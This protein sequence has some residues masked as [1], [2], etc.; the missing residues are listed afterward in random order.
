MTILDGKQCSA[1]LRDEL[2]QQIQANVLLGHRAPCLGIIQVGDISASTTYVDNKRK[3]CEYVGITACMLHLPATITQEY[4]I[5]RL[6]AWNSDPDIDGYIVQL[7]LPNH[8]NEQDV[9]CTIAAEKDVDGFSPTNMGKL[10]MGWEGLPPAMPMGIHSL[11]KEYDIPLKGKEVAIIGGNHLLVRPLANLLSDKGVDC[12]VTICHPF[13]QDVR[14][15]C[16]NADIVISAMDQPGTVTV[17]MVREGAIVVDAGNHYL[18]APN[19]KGHR[20]IGDA[21][22]DAVAPK[23]SYITPVPGGVGPMIIVSLLQNTYRAYLHNRG[24]A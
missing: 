12:T 11:L 21:D 3:A 15:H 14:Q 23:C 8:I 9:L 13:T 22:F 10:L 7:P 5:Q 18:P 19:E 20:A 24:K 4:L 16:L 6:R 17:D 1:R 2:K